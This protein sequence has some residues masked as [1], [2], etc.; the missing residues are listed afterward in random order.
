MARE[1]VCANVSVSVSERQT[2]KGCRS[3][4]SAG[5]MV[6]ANEIGN[7]SENESETWSEWQI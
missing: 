5:V 1:R 6:R 4:H 3:R 2:L 7:E